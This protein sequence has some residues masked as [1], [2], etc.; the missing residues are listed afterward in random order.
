MRGAL[1]EWHGREVVE[2]RGVSHQDVR[3]HHGVP[4]VGRRSP[5]LLELVLSSACSCSHWVDIVRM[6]VSFLLL[7]AGMW[8]AKATS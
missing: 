6:S 7:T 3:E 1:A 2:E 8:V 4:R 5:L